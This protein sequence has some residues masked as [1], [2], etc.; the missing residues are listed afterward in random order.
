MERY[1]TIHLLDVNTQKQ[2]KPQPKDEPKRPHGLNGNRG[3]DLDFKCGICDTYYVSQEDLVKH[4]VE[5]H[6]IKMYVNCVDTL[7][8]EGSLYTFTRNGTIK[9]KTKQYLV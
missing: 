5:V 7:V 9:L 2:L 1:E 3:R 6:E 4:I 8:Q